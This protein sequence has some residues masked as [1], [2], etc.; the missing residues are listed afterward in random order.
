MTDMPPP[1]GP[2]D[3]PKPL[4]VGTATSVKRAGADVPPGE[5][6][7]TVRTPVVSAGKTAVRRVV[8]VTVTSTSRVPP[9]W[10]VAV[11]VNPAPVIT[12]S[13]PPTIGALSGERSAIVG[14]GSYV[15][16]STVSEVEVPPGD[17]TVTSTVPVAG[18][19]CAL[20]DVEDS[21]V[22][23]DADV[24]PKFTIDVRGEASAGD[25]DLVPPAVGPLFGTD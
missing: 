24:V 5:V 8:D 11:T 6:T 2:A 3:G 9:I 14:T 17:V 1:T 22:T 20:I 7:V 12:T 10:T 23:V 15:N 18:G 13:T 16:R 19:A 4:T 25:C 21:T